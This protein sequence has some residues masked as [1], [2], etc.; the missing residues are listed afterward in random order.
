MLDPAFALARLKQTL[1][2]LTLVTGLPLAASIPALAE[3]ADFNGTWSVQLVTEAGACGGNSYTVVVHDGQVRPASGGGS[4]T[5][6]IGADGSVGLSV[7]QGP[8]GGS[9]SGRLRANAGS[10]SWKAASLCSEPVPKLTFHLYGDCSAAPDQ[11]VATHFLALKPLSSASGPASQRACRE[12]R[13]RLL[14]LL[15]CERRFSPGGVAHL[16]VTQ[17]PPRTGA[18]SDRR[19]DSPNTEGTSPLA[20][21]S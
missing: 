20:P 6:R 1:A 9:A 10:G 5:G 4:I 8:A 15:F 14:V 2:A 3:A 16:L 12:F 19:G 18:G 17:T 13:D 7:R 21:A 11:G